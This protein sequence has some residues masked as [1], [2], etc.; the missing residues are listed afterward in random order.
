MFPNLYVSKHLFYSKG[1]SNQQ[2]AYVNQISQAW[3]SFPLK[4]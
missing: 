4:I 1:K 2:M 3:L